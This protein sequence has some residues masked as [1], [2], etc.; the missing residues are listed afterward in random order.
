MFADKLL[1][2]MKEKLGKS[3]HGNQKSI[4]IQHNLIKFKDQVLVNL[5][6]NFKGDIFSAFTAI[7]DWKSSLMGNTQS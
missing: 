1:K 6:T 5:D 7:I 4:S 3:Q 2:D